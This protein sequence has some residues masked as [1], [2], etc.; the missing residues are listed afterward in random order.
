MENNTQNAEDRNDGTEGSS[1]LRGCPFCG[2]RPHIEHLTMESDSSD[3]GKEHITRVSCENCVGVVS[4][5][6]FPINSNEYSYAKELAKTGAYMRW[7]KREESA[8]D[9]IVVGVQKQ[10]ITSL[11]K[12]IEYLEEDERRHYDE[13]LGSDRQNHIYTHIVNVKRYLN[14]PSMIERVKT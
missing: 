11:T 10:F 6:S 2:R 1:I 8:S 3:S 5:R 7:N 14:H 9:Q 12:I 13:L 4:I